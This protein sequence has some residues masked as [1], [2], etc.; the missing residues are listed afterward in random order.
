MI[1]VRPDFHSGI[2]LLQDLLEQSGADPPPAHSGIDH[3]FGLGG[4]V[5]GGRAIPLEQL[6]LAA[7]QLHERAVRE[8]RLAIGIPASLDE[9]SERIR[10]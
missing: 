7:A 10:N 9:S 3:E 6:L 4:G 5:D 8:R 1:A 2:A